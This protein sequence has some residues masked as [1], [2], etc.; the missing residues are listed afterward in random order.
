MKIKNLEQNAREALLSCFQDIPFLK[1][2]QDVTNLYEPGVD[3]AL[4]VVNRRE[5]IPYLLV[6]EIK[7]S[8][9]PRYVNEAVN[10]L[11]V[12]QNG[13]G[14]DTYGVVLAPYISE[15]SARICKENNLGYADLA[16]NCYLSFSSV[17][18]QREGNPNPYTQ[19]RELK[20]LFYPKSERILRVLL[21]A[22]PKDWL[23][24]ELADEANTSLGQVSNVKKYLGNQGWLDKETKKLRLQNPFELL[25]A[26]AENYTFRKNEVLEY[27]SL[28]SPAETEDLLSNTCQELGLRLS[29]TG[30]SG[31]AR[32]VPMVR[33]QRVM[34]YLE[35]GFDQVASDISL[36]PVTSGANV[37][38]L[39]PYDSGV[40]YNSRLVEDTP[41]VSPI[42][43]YLD[44]NSY[45][46]RGE[47]AAQ[48]ILDKVIRELW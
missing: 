25:A 19:E 4:R 46:G 29:L 12:Y 42:Q 31:G 15:R 22:G 43:A 18:I 16:G 36:K 38:L 48:E 10:Q 23:T 35:D 27:Y 20:S 44:L 13:M 6:A 26:W 21:T 32:Y 14:N 40:F 47:E 5:E 9:Q 24:E 28:K 17:F 33:Y 1:A 3:F 30:F 39:K 45:R 34:A 41:V 11:K 2:P 7:N 37:M 8:G